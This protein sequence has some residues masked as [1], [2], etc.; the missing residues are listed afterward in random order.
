M[1]LTKFK[2]YI[3]N[4]VIDV[5]PK[6]FFTYK[7]ELCDDKVQKR[8]D[9]Y[10]KLK[11]NYKLSKPHQLARYKRPKRHSAYYFDMMSVL[12]YFNGNNMFSYEF[13]DITEVPSEPS[14]VKSRPIHVDNAHAILLKLD[15]LRH[16]KFVKDDIPFLEKKNELIG[17]CKVSP[18]QVH[19]VRFYEKYFHHPMCNLGTINSDRVNL[20]WNTKKISIKEHL[21]YKF[22]LSLEG[23]DVATNLK[24][25]MSS[26]SIAVSPKLKYETWFMEGTLI[27]DVHFICIKDDYSDLEE[28]LNYYI[29]NPN[30]ALAIIKNAN[31]YVQQF[32]CKKTE[33][34]VALG[35]LEKYFELQKS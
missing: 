28:K 23:F 3:T 6:S 10:N 20:E 18:T 9:Y 34:K 7:K 19:R 24:W 21:K 30:E 33:K 29:E 13:G 31:N 26:N 15:K 14:I 17:R 8:I 11:S 32:F 25:I 12:R 2:Y 4:G 5:L 35:V 22:I 16:F 27:P 1:R